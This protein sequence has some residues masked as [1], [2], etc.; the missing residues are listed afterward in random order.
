MP[1]AIFYVLRKIVWA[2]SKAL[3]LSM[4]VYH[5][6]TSVLKYPQLINHGGWFSDYFYYLY[7][8]ISLNWV[9]V[10][11]VVILMYSWLSYRLN[12]IIEARAQQMEVIA[13][14]QLDYFNYEP[15]TDVSRIS[16][17][18]GLLASAVVVFISNLFGI[19]NPMDT[20]WSA[21]AV[22]TQDHKQCEVNIV[23]YMEQN[24]DL[25]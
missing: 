14:S 21:K 6:F 10:I 11:L 22:R 15:V 25:K 17:G 9:S 4:L 5:G 8:F 18:T 23:Q 12:K 1:F 7:S 24:M 20:P 19:N 16:T 13:F 3:V 2:G